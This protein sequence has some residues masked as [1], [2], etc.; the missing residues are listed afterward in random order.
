MNKGLATKII[1]FAQ[2]EMFNWDHETHYK[3][4]TRRPRGL[5]SSS[6]DSF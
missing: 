5:E 2:P 1:F 6:T 3:S 4:L